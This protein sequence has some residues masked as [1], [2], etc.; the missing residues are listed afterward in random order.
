MNQWANSVDLC[1]SLDVGGVCWGIWVELWN[2]TFND[3]NNIYG[4]NLAGL[5]VGCILFV[6]F[7]LKYGRR[8]VYIFS[9]T[10]TLAST[11]WMS[12]VS[13]LVPLISS[14]G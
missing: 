13:G 10:V 8:V 4:A 12:Q 5:A 11:I 9:I 6:P 1:C 2:T 3:L 7:A 14:L